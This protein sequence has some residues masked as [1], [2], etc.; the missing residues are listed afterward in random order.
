MDTSH[1][2]LV[3]QLLHELERRAPMGSAVLIGISPRG[4]DSG[5]ALAFGGAGTNYQSRLY[6]DLLLCFA[7]ELY[8][9][10]FT[11]EKQETLTREQ[12][13]QKRFRTDN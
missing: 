3:D 10:R 12:M 6:D 4:D 2:D 5:V 13:E 7:G 9:K 11:L 1:F 8:K